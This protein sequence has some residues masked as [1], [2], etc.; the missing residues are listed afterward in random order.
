[1]KPNRLLLISI[2]VVSI[3]LPFLSFA[4]PYDYSK[5][6]PWPDVKEFPQLINKFSNFLISIAIPLAV[7]FIIYAG[8][9]LLIS[10]GDKGKITKARNMIWY[11]VL[12]FAALIVGRGFYL[13]IESILK[14]GSLR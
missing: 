13:L 1:M 7:I 12:G 8:I 6:N 3:S 11:T 14:S 2:I 5:Y 4:Q 9:L 10:G